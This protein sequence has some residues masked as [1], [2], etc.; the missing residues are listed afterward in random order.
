MIIVDAALERR[1]REGRPIR[2]GLVGAGYMGRGIALEMLTPVLGMRLV[3]IANRT[4][5][6]A[7]RAYR[8]AGLDA[9]S[10]VD[11][12]ARLEHAIATQRCVVTG[13]P[14]LLCRAEGIDA[15]IECT[16]EV[17]FGARVAME[18]I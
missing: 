16:G 11:S 18:A 6:E 8:D 14:L 2:V 3:A 9:V 17:E 10:A 1:E 15:I 13:D 5:A 12:V 4:L 7:A